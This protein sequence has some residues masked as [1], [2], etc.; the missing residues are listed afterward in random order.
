MQRTIE[1]ELMNDPEQSQA[2]A[3]ADFTEPNLRFIKLFR[4]A[5]GYQLQGHI[6]DLGCG[7]ADITIGLA[8]VHPNCLIDGI[9][10]SASMLNHG[11]KA[12]A[13]QPVNIQKKV[14]LIEG[15]IPNIKLPEQKYKAIISNSLLHHLHNPAILW[16]FIKSYG[17]KNSIVFISD[18]LRP[19]SPEKARD[20]VQ[21]YA[22]NEPDILK[23][24]FYNSLLAAFEIS[25]IKEQ[26]KLANLDSLSVTQV[27]DRHI[28]ISGLL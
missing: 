4:D 1:P 17:G 23:R 10:G 14:R 21:L 16:Q 11:R 20:I 27:S 2:Y 6:L 9:D 13:H 24:D 5:F 15:I 12:L 7:N 26:L 3:L 19:S 22:K 8:K 18:L 28:L 25:E